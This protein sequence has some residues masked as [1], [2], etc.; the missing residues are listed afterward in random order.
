MSNVFFTSDPHIGHRKVM[1]SRVTVDGRPAYPDLN[2]IPEFFG[3]YDIEQMNRILADKWDTSVRRDDV[4][5]VLGDIS[6]GTKTGQEQ[7]LE[8]FRRRPGRK[9]IVLGNHDGPHP[10][11][12]DAHKWFPLYADVFETVQSAARVRIPL[13]EG[14]V[15]AL[16]SHFPYEGDH[17]VEPRHSQWRLRNH[18]EYLLHGHTHSSSRLS[19]ALTGENG[20]KAWQIHVGLDAW[21]GWPVPLEEIQ[22]IIEILESE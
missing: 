2:N 4:V 21:N 16:L 3:D 17:T 19:S 18:G 1:A 20:D 13:A 10:M 14:H 15:S 7:A 11:H 5:W 8:W 9:R 12:R 6:S 22:H